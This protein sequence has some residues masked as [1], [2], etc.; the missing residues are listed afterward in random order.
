MKFRMD[1]NVTMRVL[2]F[3][4]C[5]VILAPAARADETFS[6][7]QTKQ[8]EKIVHDYLVKHP[9]V[10]IEVM[11]AAEDKEKADKLASTEKRIRDRHADL[12][13]DPASPVGGNPKG[14]VTIVEFFDYRCP[15]CK[16]VQPEIEALL[17]EDPR[18]RIVYK[19]F[20]ILG[21]DSVFASHIAIASI[22]QGKYPAFHEAMM[23]TRGTITEET[24]L[25]VANSVGIDVQKIQTD[26]NAPE[27]DAVI[28]KNYGLADLLDIS[29][30]PAFII[31]GKL[32]PGAMDKEGMKKLIAEARHSG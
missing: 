15:Y 5:L 21:A 27:V 30:T 23:N 18:L 22:K 19:E 26:M 4:L 10:V 31:G 12:F 8:I 24:I 7:A 32:V 16:Q 14:D 2:I 25:R 13:D 20:P 6:P 3:V 17:R 11:Q 28:K 1:W 29:G 9:E